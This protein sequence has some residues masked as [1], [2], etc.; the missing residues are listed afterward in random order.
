MRITPLE[1]RQKTF[2]KKLRGFDKD[3]VNAFLTSMSNEWEKIIDENKELRMKLDQAENEVKKLREVESSLFKTLKTAEDTGANL[4]DQATK[5]AQLHLKET[6]MNSEAMMNEAKNKAR[7]IIE[8]AEIQSR[9]AIEE[10]HEGIKELEQNYKSLE[11]YR[12]NLLNEL[13]NLSRDVIDRIERVDK[14]G[15]RF[16]LNDHLQKVKNVIRESEDM[17]NAEELEVKEIKPPKIPSIDKI[18]K[19]ISS[20]GGGRN[21]KKNIS[22]RKPIKPQQKTSNESAEGTIS[23]FDQLEED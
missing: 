2:E 9:Q 4:I 19:N 12:D 17:I 8:K 23:F 18:Q 13:K 3:E 21:K 14:E 5:S 1:I 22:E 11:S 6:K 15:T 7:A 20:E 10:M 16:K